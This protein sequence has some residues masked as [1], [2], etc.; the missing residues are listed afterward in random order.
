M[1]AS[2]YNAAMMEAAGFGVAFV[3]DAPA[4]PGQFLVRETAVAHHFG[5]SAE[6][7]IA[8]ITSTPA[9][10]LGLDDRIGY[11]RVGYDADLV[12]WGQDKLPAFLM[13]RGG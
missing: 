11:V 2:V 10:A 4:Q 9:R 8:A 5:M 7:A 3:M 6:G 12:V 13:K 1:R